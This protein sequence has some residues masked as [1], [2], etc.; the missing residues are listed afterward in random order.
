MSGKYQD[1]KRKKHSKKKSPLLWIIIGLIALVI[2]VLVAVVFR[3]V[4]KFPAAA[5]ATNAVETTVLQTETNP[6]LPMDLGQG[7]EITGISNYSGVYM[8]DGSDEIVTGVL[9]ITVKNNNELPLQYAEITVT[10]DTGDAEFSVSTLAPGASAVL[11]EKNRIQYDY[12]AE[13][14]AAEAEYVAFFQEQLSLCED[15]LKIQ[16]LDGAMNI[17]NITE[18]DITEDITIYYKNS[19]NDVFYGGIT[20]RIRL[21]GGIKAGEIRQ[22]MANHFYDPGSNIVM[23]TCGIG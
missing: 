2:C 14:T 9:M 16:T 8:E 22:I 15:K 3:N 12:K 19:A 5:P 10:G 13:Y 17:S 11:L 7:L 21:E 18:Q 4:I 20:Y 23:V 1:K 6:L